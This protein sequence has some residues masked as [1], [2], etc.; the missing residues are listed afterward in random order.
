MVF[1]ATALPVHVYLAP[2]SNPSSPESWVWVDIT[3]DVRTA[4]GISIDHG[5]PNEAATVDPGRCSMRLNNAG[6]KYS[7]RNPASQYYGQL[8]RNT[9]LRVTVETVQDTFTRSASNSWGTSDSGHAW[10]LGPG[11]AADYDVTGTAA[12]CTFTAD[13]EYRYAYV[14]GLRFADGD[15]LMSFSW[16]MASV[17]GDAV[18][19][20]VFLRG[21]AGGHYECAVEVDTAGDMLVAVYDRDAGLVGF[22]YG[23]PT[24]TQNTV[25]TL[26]VHASG[27][28][29][30]MRLWE[31]SGAE[32]TA[33]TMSV[34]V[35][36]L[37]PGWIG[38]GGYRFNG[39]T[40][41]NYVQSIHSVGVES[42]RFSGY[43][44]EWPARWD[45][46]GNDATVPLTASGVLRRLT[47]GA[48]PLRGALY[49]YVTQDTEPLAYWPLEDGESAA[50]AESAVAGG[51][52]MS[53]AGTVVFG[54]TEVQTGATA[55]VALAASDVLTGPVTA[56]PVMT[57][58]TVMVCLYEDPTD[59]A[60]GL[61][62]AYFDTP[63]GSSGVAR[64]RITV[65]LA[66]GSVILARVDDAGAATQ[67]ISMST[68]DWSAGWWPIVVT[69]EQNGSGIDLDMY[70]AYSYTSGATVTSQTLGPVTRAQVTTSGAGTS[71]C[72]LINHLVIWDYLL[73]PTQIGNLTSA[74]AG[75]PASYA[76]D[77]FGNLLEQEGVLASV[78]DVDATATWVGV[79]RPL[80]LLELVAEAAT[81][82]VGLMYERGP[83]L[84]LLPRQWRYNQT[85]AMSIPLGSDHLSTPPEPIDDDQRLRNKIS[86]EQVGGSTVT[87]TDP[88]SIA[89]VGTYDEQTSVNLR[90]PG[91]V[92]HHAGWRLHLGTVDE[93]RWPAVSFNLARATDLLDIWP[94]ITCGDVITLTDP[95]SELPPDDVEQIVEGWTERLEQF[96]WHVTM[97]CSPASP[98]T[99]GRY[100]D[101]TSKY[102]TAGSELGASA[103]TTATSLTVAT[104][105]G[106]VWTQAAAQMPFDIRVGGERITVT[107]VTGATSPQT[108]TVT[109]SINSVVKAHD[110]GAAVSL[111]SPIPYAL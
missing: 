108:F 34:Q 15:I 51:H 10:T 69:A 89:A 26:R 38:V 30:R 104:T 29:V 48:S 95:P 9:P 94:G 3:S 2:G 33:W 52:P 56:T 81:S 100:T 12:T 23:L 71:P 83:G 107:A 1:P 98:W 70:L 60:A 24:Y 59:T 75:W 20:S 109:R 21:G 85:P 39:N 72:V 84:A 28:H 11:A 32:P 55:A 79:Q 91:E 46:S 63:D 105:S 4:G 76:V 74:S 13:D 5:R 57:E 49:R 78:P 40:N 54:R 82:D 80:T 86:V 41:N 6:G 77:R 73:T 27:E 67:V 93:P 8:A 62:V 50:W 106:P 101:G 47:Q 16:G 68:Y 19:A 103:T 61:A 53:K 99:I 64:W 58:W 45:M 22:I 37:L 42:E 102:D 7:S 17:A 35:D 110:S 44:T 90:F 18:A 87:V 96:A 43:V 88:A 65:S 111:W 66:G 36:D 25:Y 14:D 92:R 97:A 31:A